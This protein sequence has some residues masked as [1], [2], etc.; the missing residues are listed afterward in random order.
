M[1]FH[2]LP[3]AILIISAPVSNA[4]T[5]IIVGK[6]ASADGSILVARND[7]GAGTTGV[8]FIRHPSRAAGYVV[9]STMKNRFS[10]RL[11][12]RSMSY[13][14]SPRGPDSSYDESGFN[15][16]GV[17]VSATETIFSNSKTLAIDPYVKDTGLVEEV[18]PTLVLSQAKTAREGVKILGSLI[19]SHGS[20][21]GFG[22]AFVDQ[23]EAWYLENAGGHEWLAE[24]IPDD[25][26]FVSAN[27]SRL[28]RFDPDDLVN[29]LSS[30]DLVAF[31]RSHDLYDPASTNGFSFRQVFGRDTQEDRQYNYP[32]LGALQARFTSGLAGQLAKND[33]AP[34]FARPDHPL[35]VAGVEQAL[36][37]YF[38]ETPSDPYT[39]GKPTAIVRPVSVYRTYQ[40]HILQTRTG[41]P[42]EIANVEYLDLG[43]TALGIYLPFYQGAEIPSSYQGVT[44]TADDQSAFW[45]FRKVQL[46]AMQDFPDLAPIVRSAYDA[47]EGSIA[48]KQAAFEAAYT[49]VAQKNP[50]AAMRMLDDF[51]RGNVDAA[52]KL[53][54]TLENTL[55]TQLSLKT[56]ERYKFAGP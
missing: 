50:A 11:P 5:T 49:E 7:D 41:L 23:K 53:T 28:G 52:L 4:C 14:G 34:T 21:E 31:A 27:Q 51:T 13:T 18:I 20:A 25:S 37:D 33:D 46:L 47:L 36:R 19:E 3:I 15:E 44:S 8:N 56:N 22:V 32:R 45:K 24:R 54:H 40:S 9:R 1:K 6:N 29:V 16:A 30:P 48:G 10:Y 39:F 17:G 43:M 38:A 2:V 42:K 12:S 55:V 35:S 26:Y